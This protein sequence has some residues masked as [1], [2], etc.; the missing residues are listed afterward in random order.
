MRDAD[1]DHHLRLALVTGATGAIGK[2]I[3]L[4]IALRPGY[5][6]VLLCRNGHNRARPRTQRIAQPQ[7]YVDLELGVVLTA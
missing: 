7:L 6:V 5:S 1:Q 4:E 3:A 2:A